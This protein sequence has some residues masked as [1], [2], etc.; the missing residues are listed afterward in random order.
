MANLFSPRQWAHASSA[1]N[2]MLAGQ[3]I[4]EKTILNEF[5]AYRTLAK[6]KEG[7]LLPDTRA[8]VILT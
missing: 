8:Q 2:L 3:V 1:G 5:Y 7:G 6:L 4:G